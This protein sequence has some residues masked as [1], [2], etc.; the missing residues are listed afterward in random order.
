MQMTEARQDWHA[1]AHLARRLLRGGVGLRHV[2]RTLRELRD[3]RADLVHRMV[4]QGQD[5]AAATCEARQL[6]GDRDALAAQMIARP[7]LRSRARR[8]A[9][10]LFVLGP[11]P[12]VAVMAFAAVA[13]VV[14]AAGALE[15]VGLISTW[16]NGSNLHPPTITI[17]IAAI[18]IRV[19]L[20]WVAPVLVGLLLCRAAA[21]RLMPAIWPLCAMAIVAL[22]SSATIFIM[23]P[24][25][26]GNA[27]VWL[28][29]APNR[30]DWQRAVVLFC[31]L[32]IAYLLLLHVQLRNPAHA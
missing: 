13:I 20:Q 30:V 23:T 24:S 10:L 21:R 27:L 25:P 19:L 31:A 28:L 8:F 29:F 3:H 7:E 4:E 12:M 15:G 11:M 16:V 1:D 2:R 5:H 26:G 14:M 9:W 6:L 18:T 17:T 22:T 32:G